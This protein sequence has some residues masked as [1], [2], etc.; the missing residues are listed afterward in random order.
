MSAAESNTI[1]AVAFDAFG[2]LVRFGERRHPYRQLLQLTTERGRPRR[3]DDAIQMMSYPGGLADAARRLG[4][5]DPSE[6]VARLEADLQ[7]ELSTIALYEESAFVLSTLRARGYRIAI[8][9]NL[10]APYGP[11]VLRLL[12]FPPDVLAWSYAVGAVKPDPTIYQKLLNMLALRQDQVLFVG[13]TPEADIAGPRR[14]GMAA[15]LLSRDGSQAT[16]G[17]W[18]DLATCLDELPPLRD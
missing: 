16:A 7:H 3:P 12:P 14:M 6:V 13:D 8:C 4:W 2:T 17:T 10:A 9:S 15:R 1:R 18:P 11:A 5:E